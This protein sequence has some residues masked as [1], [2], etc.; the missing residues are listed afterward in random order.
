M[1]VR[2][3][4][5]KG[6]WISSLW[7]A[8]AFF[9]LATTAFAAA[10]TNG[11]VSITLQGVG[12]GTIAAGRCT[13]PAIACPVG[14][15]CQCLTGAQTIVGNKFNNGSLT[16]ELSVDTTNATLPISTTDSCFAAGG[17]GSIASKNG[18]NTFSLDISGLACPT[19]GG[20][21]ETFNGTYVVTGGTNFNGGTGTINGSL[22]SGTSRSSV[23]GNLQ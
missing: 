13:S 21:A 8:A 11:L 23:N 22:S 12:N 2:K 3:N 7:L 5:S 15:T 19:V 9:S 10:N 1:I 20:S 16:F 6:M 17:F 4:R 14:H 18:K